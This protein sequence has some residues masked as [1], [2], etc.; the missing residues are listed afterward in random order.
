MPRKIDAA[1]FALTARAAARSDGCQNPPKF[2]ARVDRRL[3]Q[4]DPSRNRYEG[5]ASRRTTT[6][7]GCRSAR[8]CLSR[9]NSTRSSVLMTTIDDGVQHVRSAA[10]ARKISNFIEQRQIRA[11]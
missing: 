11:T 8:A 6:D 9:Q 3:R 1:A 10:V 4:R 2:D 7:P 5:R